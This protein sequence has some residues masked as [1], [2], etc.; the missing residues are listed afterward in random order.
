MFFTDAVIQLLYTNQFYVF[1]IFQGALKKSLIKEAAYRPIT[2]DNWYITIRLM[3]HR[4]GPF[5][6]VSTRKNGG[7]GQR[8]SQ[9][10]EDLFKRCPLSRQ[11]TFLRH[12]LSKLPSISIRFLWTIPKTAIDR[13]QVT[14]RKMAR[15]E[16]LLL[17]IIKLLLETFICSLLLF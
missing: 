6:K 9:L 1:V 17:L 10:K 4:P 16:K 15:E 3:N 12:F 2:E 8:R 7:P 5:C 11:I 13:V 14:L